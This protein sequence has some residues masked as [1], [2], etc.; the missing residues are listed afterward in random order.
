MNNRRLNA[1]TLSFRDWEEIVLLETGCDNTCGKRFEWQLGDL[2]YGFDHK[3]IYTHVGFN[4]KVTDMQA[5]LGVSQLNKADTFV[6]KEKITKTLCIIKT[7]GRIFYST[8]SNAK[9]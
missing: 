8:R 4:L 2:P 5:A 9:R 1:P 7:L 3:Y 6:Q